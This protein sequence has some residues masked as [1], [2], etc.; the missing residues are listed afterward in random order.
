MRRRHWLV[1]LLCALPLGGCSSGDSQSFLVRIG[2]HGDPTR[3]RPVASLYRGSLLEY[4]AGNTLEFSLAEDGIASGTFRPVAQDPVY[5]TGRFNEQRLLHLSGGAI[6]IDAEFRG[7]SHPD[8]ASYRVTYGVKCIGT[9]HEGSRQGPLE[10]WYYRWP[11]RL[12]RPGYQRPTY[13]HGSGGNTT[14]IIIGGDGDDDDEDSGSP[15]DGWDWQSGGGGS[16]GSGSGSGGD[17]GGGSGGDSGSSGGGSSS[18]G[19]GVID[20]G[21]GGMGDDV[22]FRRPR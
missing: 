16:S 4:G 7:A 9:W 2:E 15:W 13:D 20:G 18:S 14:V 3:A 12:N 10:A 21:G 1:G 22:I 17:S 8:D 11:P 19:D 5:L 6:T